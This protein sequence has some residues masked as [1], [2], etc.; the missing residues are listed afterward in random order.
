MSK[1][2]NE[3]LKHEHKIPQAL[4]G[5]W[6]NQ[7]LTLSIDVSSYD[8]FGSTLL[9]FAKTTREDAKNITESIS[10]EQRQRVALI[11]DTIQEGCA[12]LYADWNDGMELKPLS[13]SLNN[14]QKTW[15]EQLRFT[16]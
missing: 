13:K 8:N 5:A 16:E 14:W 1:L 2:T 11:M 12:E 3:E 9:M 7:A 15:R 10:S 4:V 6:H